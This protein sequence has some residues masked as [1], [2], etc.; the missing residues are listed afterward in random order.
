[1]LRRLAAG[2][3]LLALL[4]GCETSLRDNLSE[5]EA[6]D[7]VALLRQEGVESRKQ[8]GDTDGWSIV[9]EEDAEAGA[10]QLLHLYGAP[11]LPHPTVADIFPGTGLLPSEVEEHARYQ[12]A[13]GHDLAS[14][15]EQIDGVLASR[16]HVAMPR[17]NP[18]VRE[19]Q[20]PTA[21]VFVRYR[22]D[23]RVDLMKHQIRTLVAQA[24]PG[25]DE[26]DISVMSVPV[27]P[28]V[29]A[30][31]TRLSRSWF[32]VRYAPEASARV[33]ALVVLPW[34]L[35]AAVLGFLAWRLG[36]HRTARTWVRQANTRWKNPARGRRRRSS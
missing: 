1:M 30:G 23:Q 15:I 17:H 21:S 10:K 13:L 12:F 4:A 9:I 19:R 28:P 3:A 26:A 34:V 18:R 8:R 25:A 31:N 33:T 20:A 2:A 5:S 35:L 29:G 36:L 24:L 11:R 6:D 14:T 7:I 27:F 32:G 22:S 16:V